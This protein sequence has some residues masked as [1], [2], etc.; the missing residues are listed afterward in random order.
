MRN[1]K[2]F[3][4][5]MPL[6]RITNPK[7]VVFRFVHAP[8]GGAWRGCPCSVSFVLLFLL[9]TR[10]TL[11]TVVGDTIQA[12]WALLLNPMNLGRFAMGNDRPQAG[13]EK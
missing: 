9:M 1:H 2:R 10:V 12:T 7:N 11:A 6:W 8:Y 3:F 5:A 4:T 13:V